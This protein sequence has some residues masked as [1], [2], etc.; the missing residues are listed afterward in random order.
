MR[1]C[2]RFVEKDFDPGLPQR[3]VWSS[4]RRLGFCNSFGFSSSEVGLEDFV[5]F[6]LLL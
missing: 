4:F 6:Y 1:A 5:E 3:A 2:A